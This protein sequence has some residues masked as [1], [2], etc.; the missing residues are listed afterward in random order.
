[1][2]KRYV[3]SFILLTL[4]LIGTNLIS[5][6]YYNTKMEDKSEELKEAYALIMDK[7]EELKSLKDTEKKYQLLIEENQV[8]AQSQKVLEEKN[9]S[10]VETY[11]SLTAQFESL[12]ENSQEL[13]QRISD[14]DLLI[15]EYN[16]VFE[17]DPVTLEEYQIYIQE[18]EDRILDAGGFDKYESP[19]RW[20]DYGNVVI[21]LEDGASDK[22][23][24]QVIKYID[25]LPKKMIQEL[26][27]NG[28]ML[29]VTPR[30]LEDVYD[31][32]VTN[33]VGLTVYY[34]TRIYL[35]NNSFSI[36]FCTIHEIGHALDFIQNFI[37]Y[38]EEWINIYEKEAKNSGL[39]TY[40]TSSSSEYFAE[41]FQSC[42][43]SPEIV[44]ENAP[45]SYE[46]MIDFINQYK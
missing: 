41:T 15:Q 6:F 44:K 3:I 26:N 21:W 38:S 16:Y 20:K 42:F 32:G 30:S 10:L 46:F 19:K 14:M 11:Q 33:T 1:M 24:D 22:W 40:F 2:K 37:S 27:D 25:F 34:R 9:R 45:L 29:I 23:A 43:L 18:L 5:I 12:K 17:Y 4:L 8:L 39:A 13:E 7:E 28:W 36:D 31:S 35:Q